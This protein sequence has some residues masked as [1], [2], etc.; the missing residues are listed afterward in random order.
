MAASAGAGT[1]IAGAR[2]ISCFAVT[3][4]TL[5]IDGEVVLS[6]SMAECDND[7]GVWYWRALRMPDLT[8]FQR[9]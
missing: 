6:V 8:S 5:S 2:H 1:K 3:Q 9:E 7:D 4:G